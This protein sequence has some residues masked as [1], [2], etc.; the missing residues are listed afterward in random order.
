VQ[1]YDQAYDFETFQSSATQ[2]QA[3]I[4]ELPSLESRRKNKYKQKLKFWTVCFS[5]FLAS[6]IGVGGF[7]FSQAKLAEYTYHA[8]MIGKKLEEFKNQNEQLRIKLISNSKGVS[9]DSTSV[10]SKE[11]YV[12]VIAI[13]AGDK[14]ELS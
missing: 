2:K 12:E 6:G 3:T 4:I 9:S 5:V 10:N 7:L 8:A 14:A 13:P 1:D 11:D